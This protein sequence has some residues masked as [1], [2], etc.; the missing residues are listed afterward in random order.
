M[1]EPATF[2]STRAYRVL[3]CDLVGLKHDAAGHPDHSEVRAHVEAAGE[4]FHEGLFDGRSLEPGRLHFFYAP[5]LS[6]AEEILSAT[7]GGR[8]DAV[9]AAATIVPEAATFALGGVRIGAGTGNMRS[10]SWGGP[11]GAGGVAP[12]MN[13]PGFNS[14]ATAQMVFKCLLAAAP[15][16]PMQILHDRVMTGGFDT[17]RNLVEYPTRKLEG[18]TIAV[19][20]FGNIGREIARLARAFNMRVVVYA[21]PRHGKWIESEGFVH[22]ATAEDAAR[23]ADVLSIHT[24]LGPLDRQTGRPANAGF[25]GADILGALNPDAI[26]VNYDRGEVI[27]VPALAQALEQGRVRHAFV[28]ADIFIDGAGKASGPLA[29]YVDV[30]RRFRDRVH[31]LPHAAADT[32]HPSRVEGARQAVDQ[33]RAAIRHRRVVNLKGDLPEGYVDAG[34]K[35]PTGFGGLGE[36]QFLALAADPRKLKLFRA[37][38]RDMAA[39]WESLAAAGD[40]QARR[41]LLAASGADFVEAANR[42]AA[43]LRAEGIEGAYE[44]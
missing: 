6:G 20:G 28:D 40:E 9:I 22:A 12:L 10:A 36:R 16:L 13:T 34:S 44:A 1:S 35:S 17:G 11:D 4:A 7:A 37:L 26:V 30:A 21:R 27:D 39:F 5:H 8:Y 25:V 41:A 18:R 2:D 15:D 19:L 43:L 32:D 3:I 24:G 33:I 42:H 31:L 38:T 29:P 23:G 14:R